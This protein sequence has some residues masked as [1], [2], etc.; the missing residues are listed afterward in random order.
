MKMILF[1]LSTELD[2][3]SFFQKKYK[4]L[5]MGEVEILIAMLS[6]KK[7]VLLT[8]SQECRES[9]ISA[10]LTEL[11][12]L[13]QAELQKVQDELLYIEDDLAIVQKEAH[14]KANSKLS[15]TSVTDSLVDG[16]CTLLRDKE[17]SV[18]AK[19]SK[20]T[21]RILPWIPPW[22]LALL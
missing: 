17:E 22:K 6:R 18:S 13:K 3:Q 2:I 5:S 12:R 10:F 15:G 11:K 16:D 8:E 1:L 9:L 21:W 14:E 4:D 19:N 7:E 20:R